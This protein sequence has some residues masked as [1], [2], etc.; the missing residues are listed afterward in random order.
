[1]KHL[2]NNLSNEEKNRIREQYEGGMSVDN[3]RFKKLMESKL[4]NVKPLIMEQESDM[5]ITLPSDAPLKVTKGG[6][7]K[8]D[9]TLT[10]F[11]MSEDGT[12]KGG[13]I[14]SFSIE[15]HPEFSKIPNVEPSAYSKD[16]RTWEQ[17]PSDSQKIMLHSTN[18][19]L[20]SQ[21]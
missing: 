13:D 18:K 4:G 20:S 6:Y 10:L 8:D 16:L 11:N 14:Y 17:D 9:T 7:K 1:M 3:S 15:E 5:V 2:L 12:S 19:F 21:K